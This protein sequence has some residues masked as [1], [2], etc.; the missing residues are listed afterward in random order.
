MLQSFMIAFVATFALAA[1]IG[2]V[3]LLQ[4]LMTPAKAR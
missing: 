2:H 1:F 4:A 3:A